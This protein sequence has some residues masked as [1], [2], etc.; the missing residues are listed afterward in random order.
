MKNKNDWEL[1][2][3]YFPERK[4]LKFYPHRNELFIEE[5]DHF[6]HIIHYIMVKNKNERM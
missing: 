4:N 6:T 5:G 1:I 2:L 3:L